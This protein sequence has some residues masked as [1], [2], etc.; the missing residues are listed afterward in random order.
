[1][2]NTDLLSGS[3]S[4]IILVDLR[5]TVQEWYHTQWAKHPYINK[6]LRICFKHIFR[7]QS[8]GSNFSNQVVFLVYIELTT[9]ISHHNKYL[10]ISEMFGRHNSAS[11]FCSMFHIVLQLCQIILLGKIVLVGISGLG[12][13]S[14]LLKYFCP[15]NLPL[16]TVILIG[17]PSIPSRRIQLFL[18]VRGTTNL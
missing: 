8:D 13:W 4:A 7:S 6:Y 18:G 1:M 11:F 9:K 12:T 15:F 2:P 5:P 16:R 14:T 17:S 3:H 10:I